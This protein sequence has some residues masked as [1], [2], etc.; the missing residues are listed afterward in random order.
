MDPEVFVARGVCLQHQTALAKGPGATILDI[1]PGLFGIAKQFSSGMHTEFEGAAFCFL[2]E[3]LEWIKDW[4]CFV[5]SVVKFRQM[6][7]PISA[8]SPVSKHRGVSLDS[9]MSLFCNFEFYMSHQ[10]ADQPDWRPEPEDVSYAEWV[11]DMTYYQRLEASARR[12]AEAGVEEPHK[13]KAA[14]ERKK[15]HGRALVAASPGNWCSSLPVHWCRRNCT[16]RS[17]KDAVELVWRLLMIVVVGRVLCVCP[18]LT[19][20]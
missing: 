4:F 18:Q 12:S 11:L 13:L 2:D 5:L 20:G 3:H 17:H 7:L 16:C 8:S 6:C 15:T 10:E 19:N 9:Y 1:T 14:L